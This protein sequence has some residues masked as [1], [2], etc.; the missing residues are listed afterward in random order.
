LVFCLGDLDVPAEQL[1]LVVPQPRAVHRFDRSAHLAQRR[2]PLDKHAQPT[3]VGLRSR[4]RDDGP[5]GIA[6]LDIDSLA[7]SFGRLFGGTS[8]VT[9]RGPSS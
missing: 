4:D 5:T 2:Q 9:P 6:Y 3:H 1:E 8:S 7:A